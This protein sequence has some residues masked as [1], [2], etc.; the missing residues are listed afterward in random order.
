M[1]KIDQEVLVVLAVVVL[2][3]EFVMVSVL[4]G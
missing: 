4:Y 2:G 1:F 3:S